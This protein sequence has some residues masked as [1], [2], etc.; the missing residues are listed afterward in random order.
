MLNVETQSSLRPAS[1]L[2]RFAVCAAVSWMLWQ[3]WDDLGLIGVV[4]SVPV[5]GVAFARPILE[6]VE[7]IRG[8]LRKDA[9]GEWE[10]TQYVYERFNLR[11]YFIGEEIWFDAGD[12]L[13]V[14]GKK[15]AAWMDKRFTAG[16]FGVIPGLRQKGFSTSGVLKLAAMTVHP[17]AGKFRV[18]FERAVMLPLSRKREVN[19]APRAARGG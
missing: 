16:E 11:G 7:V 5:W 2:T 15:P 3:L 6:G 8:K 14:F 19:A 12:L 13:A 18:W 4:F 17:E 10:G 9:I 1:L